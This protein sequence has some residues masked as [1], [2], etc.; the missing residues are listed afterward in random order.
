MDRWV[1]EFLGTFFLALIIGTSVLADPVS[2]PLAIGLGLTALVY[3]GGPVSGA[4][5]NPAVTLAFLLQG[6]AMRRSDFLPYLVAQS[7]GA[8]VAAV[9]VG[10]VSGATFSPAPDPGRPLGA[11]LVVEYLF[12]LLLMLVI[13]NVAIPAEVK[14]NGYYGVAIGF[15]I[16]GAI[17]AGGGVS[18]AA[19]NPA[20]GVGMAIVHGL[21]GHEWIYVVGPIAGALSAVPIFALQHRGHPE[22]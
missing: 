19:Y 8:I 9:V 22:R 14:G 4:H 20:V 5:Y 13:L 16:G 10:L 3:M 2:A 6:G 21:R 15:V 1:T 17:F 12:T 18:G 11:A 7:L